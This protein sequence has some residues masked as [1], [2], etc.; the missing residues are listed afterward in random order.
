MTED[1]GQHAPEVRK[2]GGRRRTREARRRHAEQAKAEAVVPADVERQA[3]RVEQLERELSRARDLLRKMQ[4]HLPGYDL[5]AHRWSDRAN[6]VPGSEVPDT[7]LNAPDDDS[8]GKKQTSE[9]S[10]L[11]GDTV[12]TTQHHDSIH[13]PVDFGEM[14]F[15]PS[16]SPPSPSGNVASAQKQVFYSIDGIRVEFPVVSSPPGPMHQVWA[17]PSGD[18]QAANGSSRVFAQTPRY[19]CIEPIGVLDSQKWKCPGET[20]GAAVGGKADHDDKPCMQVGR[21]ALTRELLASLESQVSGTWDNRA[22]TAPSGAGGH[23]DEHHDD[24]FLTATRPVLTRELLAS[25]DVQKGEAKERAMWVTKADTAPLGV[26]LLLEETH[27]DPRLPS[28]SAQPAQIPS[29]HVRKREALDSGS[30]DNKA[31]TAPLI[32]GFLGEETHDDKGHRSSGRWDE[33]LLRSPTPAKAGPAPKSRDGQGVW[34][35]STP[36]GIGSEGSSP[37]AAV[38]NGKRALAPG[39]ERRVHDRDPAE[40][41]SAADGSQALEDGALHNLPQPQRGVVSLIGDPAHDTRGFGVMVQKSGSLAARANSANDG[42]GEEFHTRDASVA[43]LARALFENGASGMPRDMARLT[44]L[45][46]DG[47]RGRAEQ[48]LAHLLTDAQ[49]R[50]KTHHQ[51]RGKPEVIYTHLLTGGQPRGATPGKA[52]TGELPHLLTDGQAKGNLAQRGDAEELPQLLT[53]GRCGEGGRYQVNAEDLTHLLAESVRVSSSSTGSV[54]GSRLANAAAAGATDSPQQQQQQQ[55]QSEGKMKLTKLFASAAGGKQSGHLAFDFDWAADE[56]EDADLFDSLSLRMTHSLPYECEENTTVPCEPLDKPLPQLIIGLIGCVSHGKTTLIKMLTGKTTMVF[57]EEKLMNATIKLNYADA[58]IYRSLRMLRGKRRYYMTGGSVPRAHPVHPDTGEPCEF[59]RKLSFL[60]CPGHDKYSN[61]MLVGTSVVDAAVMVVAASEAFPQK[62]TVEHFAAIKEQQR[63][64]SRNI[65]VIHNKIDLV[66][67]Q[68]FGQLPAIRELVGEDATVI[69]CC[70]VQN[71]NKENIIEALVNLKEPWTRS[72]DASPEAAPVF[73]IVRSYECRSGQCGVLEGAVLQGTLKAGAKLQLLPGLQDPV[74]EEFAPLPTNVVAITADGVPLEQAT[75]GALVSIVTNLHPAHA[76]GDGLV[77]HVVGE[78][79]AVGRFMTSVLLVDVTRARDSTGTKMRRF[80]PG[81]NVALLG[82]TRVNA[83]V[84]TVDAT[85]IRCRLSRT[86]YVTAEQRVAVFRKDF[87]S[88]GDT[89]YT[90]VAWGTPRYENPATNHS[91]SSSVHSQQLQ[92]LLQRQNCQAPATAEAHPPSHFPGPAYYNRAYGSQPVPPPPTPATPAPP[93]AMYVQPM[94]P[95]TQHYIDYVDP[96][97]TTGCVPVNLSD[98][99]Q[100]YEYPP[101][102][103]PH[104]VSGEYTIHYPNGYCGPPPVPE[105]EYG[106][107]PTLGLGATSESSVSRACAT[108]SDTEDEECRL[109]TLKKRKSKGK[110]KS[111]DGGRDPTATT[112]TQDAAYAHLLYQALD[113]LKLTKRPQCRIPSPLVSKI[114]R[115]SSNVLNFKKIAAALQRDPEHV[116]QFI[117]RELSTK[118]ECD[119]AGGLVLQR[120][121]KAAD[122][123]VVLRKYAFAFV[124]CWMCSSGTRV[125]RVDRGLYELECPHCM[126]TRSV[127]V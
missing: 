107:D 33:T 25:L 60:D 98:L 79:S 116:R 74:S 53:D 12:P 40:I 43:M 83:T 66:G 14:Q 86:F 113:T 103:M 52:A 123:E 91:T 87:T 76:Q 27:E 105:P 58:C 36:S 92:Q 5:S 65:I 95:A 26:G 48:E 80:R 23:P 125:L 70:A 47:Q 84:I 71:S 94:S 34:Q 72:I 114:S 18:E 120:A 35:G 82:V 99:H 37:Q 41:R 108:G 126:A 109:N 90:V 49:A 4:Q 104:P 93:A 89:G 56:E 45:L 44:K 54:C 111:K 117:A 81:E 2:T 16:G 78:E 10:E 57:R 73:R 29:L 88:S 13:A 24:T 8:D 61:T 6:Y 32:V 115:C 106:A 46:T 119:N 20:G 96:S 50:S 17:P 38:G 121:P 21:P 39:H 64:A 28:S 118:A 11:E 77:G 31:D 1:R 69:P 127:P 15:D 101:H 122:V 68:A 7:K 100:A 63:M 124:I 30:W 112:G 102:P 51:Q 75:P 9:S 55:Q 42:T 62:Q 19:E 97:I 3:R 110:K 22:E 67:P 59:V 85:S